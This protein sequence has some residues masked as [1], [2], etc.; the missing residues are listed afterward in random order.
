MKNDQ[1]ALS[2]EDITAVGEGYPPASRSMTSVEKRVIAASAMGSV[3]EMYD[4]FLVGALSSEIA[5]HFFSGV[6]PS[7]GFIL[8]LLGFAAGF[9]VRPFGGMFFGRL[10]DL[11]G[12]K[13]TFL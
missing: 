4:F 2:R 3:F 11:V 9:V 10:G 12:R 5:K 6:N 7:V 1:I 13:R 8:T